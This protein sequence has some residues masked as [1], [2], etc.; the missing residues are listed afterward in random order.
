MQGTEFEQVVR[1]FRYAEQRLSPRLMPPKNFE[2]LPVALGAAKEIAIT[3]DHAEVAWAIQLFDQH[4]G[5][6]GYE[7]TVGAAL[8]PDVMVIT[9]RASRNGATSYGNSSL[10][11]VAA[12]L[13]DARWHLLADGAIWLKE[14]H[15]TSQGRAG[16]VARDGVAGPR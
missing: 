2:L 1:H 13:R 7:K 5:A 11:A 10:P 14:A 4:A 16:K 9:Q 12:R 15:G 3:G 6:E 8:D